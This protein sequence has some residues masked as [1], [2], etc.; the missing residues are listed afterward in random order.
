MTNMVLAVFDNSSFY[1]MRLTEYL[2]RNIELSF[3]IHAFTD[4]EEFLK[5]AKDRS[6]SLLVISRSALRSIERDVI[7]EEFKNVIILEEMVLTEESPDG[8]GAVHISK[9][10]PAAMI[11]DTVI[12]LCTKRAEDFTGLGIRHRNGSC[13]VIG[14]YTPISG[15]G[16]TSLAVQLGEALSGEGKT[17]LLSFES[18]SGLTKSF[19]G[20]VE[21]DITDLLYYAECE[22][23]KFCLYLERIKL[24]RSGLDYIAPAK[25]AAQV[26]ELSCEKLR[27]LIDLLGRQAGYEYVILDL[28][29]YPEDFFDILSMCDVVYTIGRNNSGDQYRMGRYNKVL[30]ENGYESVITRTIKCA[31]PEGRGGVNLRRYIRQL[32]QDG[33]EVLE[34]GA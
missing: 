25:T 3:D 24:T 11:A 17:L 12:G 30:C 28:K 21:E 22:R 5:Y 27:N 10:L 18:F 1:C 32:I 16:Q 26:R 34:I 13:R 33:R 4:R 15:C 23:E 2:R 8:D 9:Y 20:D 31:F 6:I 7:P 14:L 29:D 19:E